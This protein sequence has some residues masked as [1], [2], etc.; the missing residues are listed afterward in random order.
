MSSKAARRPS[1]L[2]IAHRG[3]SGHA[4][5]NTLAAFALAL[6]LGTDALELDLRPTRDGAIVVLH[7]ETVDRTTN[8]RGRLADL[9][10]RE[11]RRLDA[12]AWFGAKFR[13]ERIPLLSEVLALARPHG[14]GLL[15]ELKTH[16]SP[17]T[18]WLAR[19]GKE[20][21]Q[22]GLLD[23]VTFL[24]FEPSALAVV[25]RVSPAARTGWLVSRVPR[26]VEGKL[27]AVQANALAPR[28]TSVTRRLVERLHAAGYPLIVWTVDHPLLMRRF[29]QLG[30]DALATNF[31]ERLNAVLGQARVLSE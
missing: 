12:G 14:I 19:V 23:R 13:S 10:R 7:D 8:G 17:G 27:R 1:L 5:E 24:G 16:G 29:V 21:Q 20:V 11:V 26:R 2:R 22:A 31:P 18:A 6:K 3:A 25:K 9:T 28:W 4:P 30:V 15:L